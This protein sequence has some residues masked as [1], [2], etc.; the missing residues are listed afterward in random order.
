MHISVVI[1][2]YNEEKSLEALYSE[3]KEA[4]DRLP[5]LKY[6]IIFVDDGSRDAS[7][8]KLKT[9][10][11]KDSR[12]KI[13]TFTRNYGQTAAIVAGFDHASGDYVVTLDADLQNDPRDIPVL[14]KK[15]N[16]GFDLVSGW[17]R[18]RKDR[19]ISRKIPSLLANWII[20]KAT[21]VRLHDFGCTLKAYNKS[22]L[23]DIR[24]Y[25]EMHRYIPVYVD[26][27]GGRIGE[28]EVNH[29]SRQYGASKNGI[30]RIAKVI[31]DLFTVKLLLG[32]SSTSP[33]YFFGGWGLGGILL[34]L[35]CAFIA[36]TQR[37][38]S[39]SWAAGNYLLLL[40]VFFIIAGF[41]V[42]F[43]GLLAEINIRIYYESGKRPIYSVAQKTNL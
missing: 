20:R 32:N 33:L 7:G 29:R 39:G 19:L 6:E 24:L 34:G 17:R 9:L 16:E 11:V 12:V 23:K 38:I 13:I 42:I 26:R 28:V 43:M 18:K 41:Q 25:G 22:F 27:M 8:E 2:V 37:V 1:P 30:K 21:G 15:I 40:C 35:L 31:F 36:L 4:L 10:S 5:S 3:L 14:L